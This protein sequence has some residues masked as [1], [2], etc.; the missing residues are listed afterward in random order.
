MIANEHLQ[1]RV[2]VEPKA[3]QVERI[4]NLENHWR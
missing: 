4:D 1:L 3:L 2:E